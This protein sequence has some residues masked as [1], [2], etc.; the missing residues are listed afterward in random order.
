MAPAP[1]QSLRRAPATPPAIAIAAAVYGLFVYS[2]LPSGVV[3]LDD[4]FGY[5]RSVVLTLRHGRPWTDDWLEPWSAGFSSLAG[6]LFRA[7]GSFYLASYGLLS[8]LAAALFFATGRM[9]FDRGI[10]P[11]RSVGLAF[12]GLTVPT[13]LWKSIEFTGGAFYLPCLLLALGL[14]ER[15]RWVWFGMAWIAAL[16]TRQSALAWAI[17]PLAAIGQDLASAGRKLPARTWLAPGLVL[18]AGAGSYWALGATMNRTAVQRAITDHM[19][20]S[21]SFGQAW[22]TL[23]TGGVVLVLASGLGAIV[24]RFARETSSAYRRWPPLVA[25]ALSVGFGA[26]L[27]PNARNFIACDHPSYDHWMGGIYLKGMVGLAGFGWVAG[28]CSF[29]PVPLAGALAALAALTVRGVLWDYYLIDL[30]VFAFF[31]VEPAKAVVRTIRQPSSPGSPLAI[32][33]LVLAFHLLFLVGFK[34]RLDRG[35]AL[36][37]LGSRALSERLLPPREAS[38]LPF[39]LMAWYFFPYYIAHEGAHSADLGDFGRY[40]TQDTVDIAWQFSKPLRWLP[41]HDGGLPADRRA[42]VLSGRFNYCWIFSTDVLLLRAPSER[43]RPAQSPYPDTYD[44]P[45]FPTNDAGWRAL[46]RGAP[47][48][49]SGGQAPVAL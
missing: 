5:L 1:P 4:D 26:L 45:L 33:A 21:W 36:C 29:R 18:L 39:G 32:A 15:R 10:G 43:A 30:A 16:S 12:L 2:I 42:A 34:D 8:L 31:A 24:L 19:W 23:L 48:Q 22:P 37:T 35:Y 44:L 27:W 9:L 13:V 11:G 25:V 20:E 14:A 38:F 6:L 46:I 17:L 28:R 41:E 7:T 49:S 40:L 47:P 3:A